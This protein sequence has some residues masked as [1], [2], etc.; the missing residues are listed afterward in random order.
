MGL[1]NSIFFQERQRERTK[2]KAQEAW[3]NL[4]WLMSTL[5]VRRP[6]GRSPEEEHHTLCLNLE[7][8][9]VENHQPFH[10]NSWSWVFSIRH[11]LPVPFEVIHNCH[12][13]YLSVKRPGNIAT[14]K[15]PEVSDEHCL[16]DTIIPSKSRQQTVFCQK[17]KYFCP[18]DDRKTLE[19]WRLA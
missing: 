19:W 11:K 15:L 1:D 12:Y 4:R 17:V 10:R 9:P 7:S 6:C 13:R 8:L 3:E 16:Q 2:R 5:A 18:F 14:A